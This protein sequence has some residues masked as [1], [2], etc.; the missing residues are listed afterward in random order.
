MNRDVPFDKDEECDLCGEIGAYDFMGDY[1]CPACLDHMRH[2]GCFDPEEED[3]G[4]RIHVQ[5]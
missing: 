5:R 4:S 2:M 3:D 1:V